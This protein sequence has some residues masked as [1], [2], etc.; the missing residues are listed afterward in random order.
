MTKYK[1]ILLS[2]IASVALFACDNIDEDE[3]YVQMETIETK[4][5]VLLEEFTGQNCP[6]CPTAHETAAKL[7][8]QYG[9]ALITV[10][11]HAG[12]FA[13]AEGTRNFPTFKTPEGDTYAA[14]WNIT[15]YPSGVINRSSG[16]SSY[17]DW[18]T[19][20]REELQKESSL[21]IE[22]TATL[23]GDGTSIEINTVI[24]PISDI[25]GMLQIWVTESG[26]ISRQKNGSSFI[27]EYEHN[28]VYRA[29]VNGVGG[30]EVELSSNVFTTLNHSINAKEGWNTDNLSIVAFVYDETGVLQVTECKIGN[31]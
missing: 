3:R 16:K 18:A 24:K 20:I 15:E 6:N 17:S 31:N 1:Y 14:Q 11:I 12:A 28:H 27:K 10:S 30:E 13:W 2:I 21:D 7:K 22:T 26:I 8:E 19:Y 25:K 5:N 4:R 9:D 29:S 23:N